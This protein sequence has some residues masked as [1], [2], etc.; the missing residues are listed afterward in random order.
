MQM[1]LATERMAPDIQRAGYSWKML[2]TGIARNPCRM[3]GAPAIVRLSFYRAN[4]DTQVCSV[5]LNYKLIKST[6]YNLRTNLKSRVFS[7]FLVNLVGVGT[8]WL[9][10]VCYL[11]CLFIF[12]PSVLTVLSHTSCC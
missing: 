4:C 6:L 12:S 7:V 1:D 2:G 8:M 10:A 3:T 11:E 9:Q 5:Q